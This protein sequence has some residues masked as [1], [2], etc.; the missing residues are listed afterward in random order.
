M[1]NC[2]RFTYKTYVSIIFRYNLCVYAGYLFYT[3]CQVRGLR[4]L[5]FDLTGYHFEKVPINIQWIKKVF[6]HHT[7]QRYLITQRVY[8]RTHEFIEFLAIENLYFDYVWSLICTTTPVNN[9]NPTFG[10]Q[11]SI[12]TQHAMLISHK[13]IV[14]F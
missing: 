13:R 4:N 3:G 14:I 2:A 11:K 12:C 9:E 8:D 10:N 7:K 5:R 1:P 6:A